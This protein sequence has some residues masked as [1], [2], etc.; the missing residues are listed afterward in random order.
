MLFQVV[1]LVQVTL[2]K[3]LGSS[4]WYLP[5]FGFGYIVRPL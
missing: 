5:V 2:E 3:Q 4:N 1:M